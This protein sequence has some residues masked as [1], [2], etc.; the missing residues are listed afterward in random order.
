MKRKIILIILSVLLMLSALT[1]AG[2]T[3][4]VEGK[5]AYELAVECGFK[6]TLEEWLASLK[7]DKGD[8]GTTVTTGDIVINTDGTG[9]EKYGVNK[10]LLSVVSVYSNFKKNVSYY[11]GFFGPI[12]TKTYEYYSAGS[13]VIYKLDKEKG[14]AYIITNYHVVYD[15]DSLTQNKISDDICIFVYGS[16]NKENAIKAT[17][18]GG[19]MDYD[20]AVLKVEN[21]DML[22]NASVAAVEVKD[23]DDIAAGDLAI[24]IG[25]PEMLGISDTVGHVSV[26]DEILTMNSIDGRS[27]M[28][29]RVIRIDTAINSGNSGGGLFDGEGKL[30]GIVNAKMSSSIATGISYA[31]PSNVAINVAD[32]VIFYCADTDNEKPERPVVEMTADVPESKAYFNP[33]TAVFEKVEK[34]TVSGVST[35]NELYSAVSVGDIFVSIKIGDTEKKITRKYILTDMILKAKKNDIIEITL[36]HD[37][38]EYTVKVPVTEDILEEY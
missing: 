12:Y 38:R 7:G 4:T 16:E 33:E 10:G 26:V 22:K 1:F 32:S 15:S 34:V 2:C 14:S 27:T 6:G 3:K 5:S 13:G 24:A 23:S 8:S 20:I 36:S 18:I 29:N 28:S 11:E 19:S 17:F 30:M 9:S 35:N 21:S 37:G 25:N 31:I